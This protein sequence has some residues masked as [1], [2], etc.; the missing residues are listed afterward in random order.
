MAGD[1]TKM[2]Y[3]LNQIQ[4]ECK[5]WNMKIFETWHGNFDNWLEQ[6]KAMV[7]RRDDFLK[8]IEINKQDRKIAKLSN[9]NFTG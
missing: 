2:E 9:T 1:N 4:T 3:V 5:D 6:L 7:F 8:Q